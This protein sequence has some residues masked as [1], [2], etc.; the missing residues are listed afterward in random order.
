MP[1]DIAKLQSL[2]RRLDYL[3]GAGE[4]VVGDL[5]KE[6]NNFELEYLRTDVIPKVAALLSRETVGL[7]CSIDCSVQSSKGNVEY[8]FCTDNSPLVKGTLSVESS[9]SEGEECKN[10]S[11]DSDVINRLTSS[12]DRLS[13]LS[14]SIDECRI[15]ALD[16]IVKLTSKNNDSDENQMKLFEDE[17]SCETMLSAGLLLYIHSHN[18][19][20]TGRLLPN[21]KIVI[22]KG[23]ILTKDVMSSYRRIKIREAILA[24]YCTLVEEGYLVLEDLPPMSPSGAGALSLGRSTNGNVAWKDENGVM[25]QDLA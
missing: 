16:C 23:S 1:D 15:D 21:R 11:L 12:I 17:D 6:I 19:N 5:R 14:A 10:T 18:C 8:T 2:Y 9:Q 13:D 20:V 22:L 4:D 25:L 3:Q 24:R 7:R